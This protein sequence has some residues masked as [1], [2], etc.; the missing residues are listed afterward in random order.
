[1]SIDS[2]CDIWYTNSPYSLYPEAGTKIINGRSRVYG[3][4]ISSGDSGI[5]A[6]SSGQT[7]SCP[8][9]LRTASSGDI[10]YEAAFM[11][12]TANAST[13]SNFHTYTHYFGGNGILFKDGVWYGVRDNDQTGSSSAEPNMFVGIIYSGGVNA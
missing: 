10:L 12:P 1:M 9:L 2:Y 8:I 4:W 5:S 13:L 11:A 7:L 6:S 3:V